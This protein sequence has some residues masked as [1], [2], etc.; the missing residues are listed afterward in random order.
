MEYKL[1][2]TS[3]QALNF[4]KTQFFGNSSITATFLEKKIN[5]LKTELKRSESEKIVIKHESVFILAGKQT[6]WCRNTPF[7]KLSQHI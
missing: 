1:S 5:H 7:E 3:E 4:P 2:M 6:I